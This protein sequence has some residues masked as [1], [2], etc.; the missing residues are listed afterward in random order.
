MK[1]EQ[2]KIEQLMKTKLLQTSQEAGLKE[3]TA[4]D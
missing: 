3:G 2:T 4:G 1:V